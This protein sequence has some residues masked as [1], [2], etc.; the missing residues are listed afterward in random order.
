MTSFSKERQMCFVHFPR[1]DITK[2]RGYKIP[3]HFY[4]GTVHIDLSETVSSVLHITKRDTGTTLSPA[5]LETIPIFDYNPE[6]NGMEPISF[7]DLKARY[8]GE[9][10]IHLRMVDPVFYELRNRIQGDIEAV[11]IADPHGAADKMFTAVSIF[12]NAKLFYL[13]DVFD[14]ATKPFEAT[15]LL[16]TYD[17]FVNQDNKNSQTPNNFFY[18][19][20]GNHDAM[21]YGAGIGELASLAH[22]LRFALRY[23]E[24][25]YL[26]HRLGLDLSEAVTLAL[27]CHYKGNYKARGGEKYD[28]RDVNTALEALFTDLQLTIKYGD[29]S[30]TLNKEEKKLLENLKYEGSDYKLEDPGLAKF[31]QRV[32]SRQKLS[33]NDIQIIERLKRGNNQLSVEASKLMKNLQRQVLRSKEMRKLVAFGLYRGKIYN[34]EHVNDHFIFTT[35]SNISINIDGSFR[36]IEFEGQNLKGIELLDKLQEKLDFYHK[37]FIQLNINNDQ[38]VDIFLKDVNKNSFF[39]WLAWNFDSP[40]Y[41]RVMKTFERA[42]LSKESGTYDEPRDYWY[43]V[44]QH[45]NGDP[46]L[47]GRMLVEL[48]DQ[49]DVPADNIFIIN[50]HTPSKTGNIEVFH[51]GRI[52]RI[53]GGSSIAY[54]DLGTMKFISSTG[55]FYALSLSESPEI[56]GKYVL[57]QVTPYVKPRFLKDIATSLDMT[58]EELFSRLKEL[59]LINNQGHFLPAFSGDFRNFLTD[60]SWIDT[61]NRIELYELFRR[62]K[63]DNLVELYNDYVD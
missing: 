50:G 14:R 58:S 6:T 7:Q 1:L 53:D 44:I 3:Y 5:S 34:F 29:P 21:I 57:T 27:K 52:I 16:L 55:D 15:N 49:L 40:V 63:D 18:G 39:D 8:A 10:L 56:T 30:V 9:K 35:H 17:T 36:E 60:I 38:E 2:K 22:M 43:Q 31:Y 20:I 37:K 32:I 13:G 28:N 12:P 26:Q 59:R 47:A 45:E 61:P 11:F 46:D 48:S 54:K 51:G 23:N 19:N 62:I 4:K 41:G 24:A 25:D 42:Y 33:Q